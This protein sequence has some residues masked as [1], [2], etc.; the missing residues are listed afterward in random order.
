MFMSHDLA[1]WQSEYMCMAPPPF[2]H[3][4]CAYSVLVPYARMD[5]GQLHLLLK[6]PGLIFYTIVGFTNTAR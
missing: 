3:D 6:C 5:D 1:A 2:M 4:V